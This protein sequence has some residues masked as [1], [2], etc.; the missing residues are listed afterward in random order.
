MRRREVDSLAPETLPFIDA[1]CAGV[2][3]GVKATSLPLEF[4]MVGY[5]PD[6]W[7]RADV[8]LAAKMIGYVG[9]ASTQADVEKF[10]FQ[11]LQNGVDAAR[12]KELFPYI[13]EDI[14]PELIEIIKKTKS[15]MP[16]ISPN[17]VWKKLLPSFSASNNWVVS[18]QKSASGKTLLSADPHLGLQFPNIWYTAIL[19]TGDEFLMGA[20]VAGAPAVAIGRSKHM[21][22]AA[23]YGTMDI[24]DFYIEDIQDGKYRRGENWIPLAVREEVIRPKK[25]APITLKIC[26]TENGILEGEPKENGYHLSFAVSIKRYLGGAAQ[27]LGNF[28]KFFHCESVD[29]ALDLFAGLTFSP[30]NWIIGDADGNIGYQLAGLFPAKRAGTS[31]LLPYLGWDSAD[32]WQGVVDFRKLPRALNPKDGIVVTANNDFNHLGEVKP[33]NLPMSSYRVDLI[34]RRLT[35]KEKFTPEDMQR[36]HYDRY[37]LQAE[38]FMQVIR[39]LLPDS[40]NGKILRDWDLRYTADSVG[41]TLFENVYAE[42]VKL[43]FGD[44]GLGKGVM[45]FI[46]TETLLFAMTS[47]N[48]DAI[49]LSESS[50][51][52]AGKT[53]EEIFK[54]AIHARVGR[55]RQTSRRDAA[56]L[57][58]QPVLRRETPALP[59]LRLSARTHR[60]PRHH[61][62][63]ATVSQ[64]GQGQFLRGHVAHGDRFRHGG[65]SPQHVGRRVG[66]PLLAVLQGGDGGLGERR[67]QGDQAVSM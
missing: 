5:K 63:G 61:P 37:S 31:G 3:A 43:V 27:S 23:T 11:M 48:F 67:L 10:I 62:A 65:D 13:K 15:A 66:Q 44:M 58:Q 45:D 55:A 18:P 25:G 26:S 36:I 39:P 57:H 17:A 1:Y 56:D 29:K 16:I 54:E 9:L 35:E 47:G 32:D 8:L 40:P 28:F 21:G 24:S 4:R 60:K 2:N 42:L 38:I 14:T 12:V 52:F 30:F 22:W 46:L 53:R 50:V 7:T 64:C 6:E 33:M 51:W 49:L 41:A 19:T 20:S 59:R 34:R